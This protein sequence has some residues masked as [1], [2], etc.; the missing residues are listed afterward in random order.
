MPYYSNLIDSVN[1]L[2]KAPHIKHLQQGVGQFVYSYPPRDALNENH[3]HLHFHLYIARPP[4]L[5]YIY[6]AQRRPV[7]NA[8]NHLPTIVG[9]VFRS[10]PHAL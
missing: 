10:P 7:L 4:T 5:N 3:S 9:A 8:Y 2:K 1:T 6:N